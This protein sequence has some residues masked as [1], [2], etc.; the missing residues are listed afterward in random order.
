MEQKPILRVE[1]YA[2]ALRASQHAKR[3]ELWVLRGI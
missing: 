3:A 1:M 2:R